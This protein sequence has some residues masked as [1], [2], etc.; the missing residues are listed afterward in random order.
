MSL[1]DNTDGQRT[2]QLAVLFC[3][4]SHTQPAP[5]GQGSDLDLWRVNYF[6]TAREMANDL[7]GARPRPP[8]AGG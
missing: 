2:E 7:G 3:D 5:Q 4:L 1:A 6:R 8:P